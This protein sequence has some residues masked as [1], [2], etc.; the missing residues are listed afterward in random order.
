MVS[1]KDTF[2][3]INKF[4]SDHKKLAPRTVIEYRRDLNCFFNFCLKEY[5]T[6]KA[7]DIR[8]YLL[9]LNERGYAPG[10][11][12]K[13]LAT[14]NSFYHYCSQENLIVK[15]P[16]KN[17]KSPKTPDRQPVYLDKGQLTELRQ[18]AENPKKRAIIE[19]LY[20]TGVRLSEL[21]NINCKT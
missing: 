7:S 20:S 13:I 15:D 11:I 19:T 3:L 21:I 18:M 10:T 4:L 8:K 9:N 17:I 2:N 16:T 14:L 12:G 6:V 5:D 1:I